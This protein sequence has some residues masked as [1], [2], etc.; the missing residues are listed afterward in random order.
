MNQRS[1]T[2]T[3]EPTLCWGKV[4]GDSVLLHAITENINLTSCYTLAQTAHYIIYFNAK[5]AVL[6]KEMGCF[7][8]IY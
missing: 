8:E 6:F 2:G 7:P 1:I 3:P 4:S 5:I